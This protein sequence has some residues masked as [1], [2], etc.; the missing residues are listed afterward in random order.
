MR[1]VLAIAVLLLSLP[2]I[3]ADLGTSIPE[4]IFNT[5]RLAREADGTL[6]PAVHEG[7]HHGWD[8]ALIVLSVLALTRARL[9]SPRLD[10]ALRIWLGALLAYGLVNAAQDFWLEQVVKREWVDWRIPGALRPDLTWIWL[11]IVLLGAAFATLLFRFRPPLDV[12]QA[13]AATSR[14]SP[15]SP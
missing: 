10:V 1:V 11:V 8:G 7:H 2:W 12:Q 13:P 9:A 3:A 5:T 6:L 4:G 15:A 14:P